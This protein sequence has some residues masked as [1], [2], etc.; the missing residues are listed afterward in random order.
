MQEGL[1]FHALAQP[2]QG[3]YFEQMW[4]AFKGKLDLDELRQA[5]QHLSD[6]HSILRTSVHWDGLSRPHQV[7]HRK[8]TVPVRILDWRAVDATQ[9]ESRFDAL[10]EEER[11]VGFELTAAPLMRVV[12]IRVGEERWRLIWNRHHLILD[13]WST[14]LLFRDL[15]EGVKPSKAARPF[16]DYLRY[17]AA[18][19]PNAA[20]RY[21]RSRLAGFTE[22]TALPEVR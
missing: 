4:C 5:W 14:A 6:R 3:M 11:R 8:V 9:L 21:W 7:V 2:E 22:P 20:E 13:G 16:S 19:D 12:V 17:L 18:Q 10:R 15:F 1:L